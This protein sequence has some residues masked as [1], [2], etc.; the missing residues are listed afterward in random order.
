MGKCVSSMDDK[1]AL[2]NTAYFESKPFDVNISEDDYSFLQYHNRQFKKGS[3]N[4]DNNQKEFP[5]S[6]NK[7]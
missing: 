5:L 4:F 2:R 6:T 7:K 1:G 3:C